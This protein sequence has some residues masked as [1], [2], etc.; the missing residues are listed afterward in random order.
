MDDNK[1]KKQ[2]STPWL[3]TIVFLATALVLGVIVLL[4]FVLSGSGGPAKTKLGNEIVAATGAVDELIEEIEST[5]G[6]AIDANTLSSKS[7]EIGRR[8][9]SVISQSFKEAASGNISQD[10]TDDVEKYTPQ[11]EASAQ[12]LEQVADDFANRCG[13]NLPQLQI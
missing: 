7:Q 6:C 1:P 5:D 3:V 4:F 2:L 10:L 13:Y 8:V 11:L 12:K 9:L